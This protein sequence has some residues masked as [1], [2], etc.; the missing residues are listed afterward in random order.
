MS[1]EPVFTRDSGTIASF[2]IMNDTYEK[3]SKMTVFA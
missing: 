3:L 2:L 1:V